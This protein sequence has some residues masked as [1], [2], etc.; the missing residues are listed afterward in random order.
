MK[1]LILLHGALGSAGLFSPLS[2]Q[3][4]D[5]K[6]HLFNFSGHGKSPFSSQ[7]FHIEAFADELEQFLGSEQLSQAE[8]FGYSMG[9][10]VALYLESLQPSTFSKITTLGTKFD[11]QPETA[12]REASRLDP[13]V[14]LEKVP[15][16]AATLEKRHGRNWKDLVRATADMMLRLGQS[17]LLGQEQLSKIQI[18]VTVLLGDQDNMVSSEES[19][20]AAQRL[21]NGHFHWL[22]NTPHPLEK[23][24]PVLLARQLS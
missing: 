10:Y 5:F 14:I 3:L 4:P 12:T 13:E 8:V 2:E 22:E 21:Q 15:A 18:P 6:V 24:N 19:E 11:W 16:F 9:G 23:V 7:G 20:K 1:D 17:P